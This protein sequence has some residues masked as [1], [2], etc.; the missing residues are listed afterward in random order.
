V[1]FYLQR[2][3][4]AEVCPLSNVASRDTDKNDNPST[5]EDV[6]LNLPTVDV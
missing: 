2:V 3:C 4:S 5:K 1:G 6:K